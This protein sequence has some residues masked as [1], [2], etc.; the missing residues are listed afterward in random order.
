[1]SRTLTI[2]DALYTRLE[3]I[4]H[5]RGFSSIEQ[6]LEVWPSHEDTLRHRQAVVARIEALRQ[7]L[8]ATYGRFPDSTA[9]VR[10]GRAR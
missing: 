1:M 10:E 3:R 8:L 2:P 6:L 4:A 7:R 9:D 5:A